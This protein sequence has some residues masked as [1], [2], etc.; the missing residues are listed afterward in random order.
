M[1]HTL[2][3]MQEGEMALAKVLGRGQVTLPREVRRVARIKPGDVANIEVLGPGLLRLS[4]LPRLSPRELRSRY[5]IEGPIDEV[6][7]R[8]AWEDAAAEETMKNV[9]AT[10]AGRTD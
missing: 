3:G 2:I 6:A 7:D 1:V 9:R 8:R 4:V 5:P 10:D